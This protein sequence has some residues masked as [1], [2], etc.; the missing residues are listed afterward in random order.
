[1]REESTQAEAIAAQEARATACAHAA[2]DAM[3]AEARE[4]H[5]AGE[6]SEPSMKL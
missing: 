2:A 4:R 3:R 5:A 6:P 1:V